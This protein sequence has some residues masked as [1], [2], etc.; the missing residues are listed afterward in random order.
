MSFRLTY[1]TMF[2]PPEAMHERFEV[3][4]A[5]VRADLGQRH[6]LFIDGADR[7]ARHHA[8]RVSPI[9]SSLAW[10]ISR[11]PAPLT[12]RR[13]WRRHRQPFRHGA[14]RRSPSGRGWCA[15]SAIS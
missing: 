11:S 14:R 5:T 8:V 15:G 4:M 1:A 12:S 7:D 6:A 9:D 10:A 13:R 2:N 3:A